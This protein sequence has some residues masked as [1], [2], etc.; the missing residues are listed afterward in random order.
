MRER[1]SRVFCPKCK[2]TRVNE[3]WLVYPLPGKKPHKC[4]NCGHYFDVEVS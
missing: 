3:T 2:S 1:G 4:D